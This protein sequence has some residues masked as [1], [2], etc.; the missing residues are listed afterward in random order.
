MNYENEMYFELSRIDFLYGLKKKGHV[1]IYQEAHTLY[2]LKTDDGET[3]GTAKGRKE[4]YH[5]LRGFAE[6]FADALDWASEE[7]R[8]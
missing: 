5:Y 4:F 1:K 2:S 3:L 7:E 6:G 8:G